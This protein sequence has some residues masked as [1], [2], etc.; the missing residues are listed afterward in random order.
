MSGPHGLDQYELI[1]FLLI[2]SQT[3]SPEMQ[4]SSSTDSRTLLMSFKQEHL[5][6]FLHY[7]LLFHNMINL[8]FKDADLFSPCKRHVCKILYPGCYWRD[9]EGPGTC[10]L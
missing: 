7:D 2:L 4:M 8:S 1:R 9:L 6:A 10:C 5:K 3:H